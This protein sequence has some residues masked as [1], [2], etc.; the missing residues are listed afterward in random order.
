MKHTACFLFLLFCLTD[1]AGCSKSGSRR[2]PRP[3]R[4]ETTVQTPA[5]RQQKTSPAPATTLPPAVDAAEIAE[6]SRPEAAPGGKTEIDMIEQNGVY[7]VPVY[8]NE[9]PM[10]FIFDTG[11]SDISLSATEA[12]FLYRQGKLAQ[13]DV[14]GK[15]QFSD[16][17]GDIS[18][19]TV[20]RLNTVRIGDRT[21][22]DVRASVVDNNRAPLLLGQSA[23]AQ[24]GKISIDYTR[25]K[26]VFE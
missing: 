4:A 19:G 10:T 24:F 13:S 12:G 7:T 2:P 18:T 6:A 15:A 11:A 21:L 5:H 1:C 26:I 22:R 23:L 3:G 16:A 25:K 9:V 8:V 17:N 20:I 14:I